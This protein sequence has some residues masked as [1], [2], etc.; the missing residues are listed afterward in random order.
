MSST[1]A[2]GDTALHLVDRGKGRPLLLVHGFPLDH[3]M[4]QE[5]IEDLS[6][7]FRV[8]APDLRGFGG[9]GVARETLTMSRL[10]DD[11]AELLAAI[12]LDQPVVYC[13]LSMGGYVA[14]PFFE[15]HRDR[16]DALILCDTRAAADTPDA[17]KGRYYLTERVLRDGTA[18]INDE[19]LRKLV[20]DP[21]RKRSP[22][23]VEQ[24]RKV[25]E[26]CNPESAA[27]AL[28]G[29]AERPDKRDL[30][31]RIDCPVLVLC[32]DQDQITPAAEMEAMAA[33]IPSA[34]WQIVPEAGHMA[35]LEN[36]AVV[37]DAIRRFLGAA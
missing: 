8:L 26:R 11:L 24:L 28:R 6:S 2:I 14:W 21:V 23:K 4:W 32:G 20:A 17:A 19:M 12:G 10:A 7:S 1:I 18:A 13:G 15:R 36:P 29:M 5:Q 3:T 22:E 9:S 37:N 35:P 25:I 31:P 33:E 30:L 16:L 27:A 34:T